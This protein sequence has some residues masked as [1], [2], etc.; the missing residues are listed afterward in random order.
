LPGY[1]RFQAFLCVLKGIL[2]NFL[3]E[4]YRRN[5]IF[6]GKKPVVAGIGE[7]KQWRQR[8]SRTG[9]WWLNGCKTNFGAEYNL[10]LLRGACND[11]CYMDSSTAPGVG[12]NDCG[13]TE[14]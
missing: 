13:S 8:D 4:L 10:S 11:I 5:G 3:Q 12:R 7:A 1:F 6:W 14:E 2:G 9:W